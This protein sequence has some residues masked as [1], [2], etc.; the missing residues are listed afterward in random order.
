TD[1]TDV[2]EPDPTLKDRTAGVKYRDLKAGM[3]EGCPPGA[4]V[5]IHYTGWLT[6]GTVFDSS[7]DRG[8]PADFELEGLIV[9][10]QEGIPGMKKGGVRKLVLAPGKG[11]GAKGSGKI[12]PNS[13]LIF[14]VEMLA[15]SGGGG[16]ADA[17]GP[18]RPGPATLTD[19][20]A[21][22]ADDP[23][24]KD[25]GGG[26]KVRDLKEGTG[27]TCEPGATVV[28]HYTG[29]LQNGKVFDS[30]RPRGEPTEFSLGKVV[31]GWQK[32]I[33]GMKIGGVRKLV[34]PPEMAYGAGGR[35]GIPPNSTLVFEVELVGVK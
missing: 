7:R 6:D 12:P 27:A 4:K 16:D 29:W 13:T 25:I 32:G 17:D 35:P 1:G 33:P 9:G 21:P 15:F 28:A 22:G 26:L 19:G 10:W 20:T 34:I 24:L 2:R 5:K 11:Y 30:S 14:E 18:A 3:G 23:G 31:P 8:K